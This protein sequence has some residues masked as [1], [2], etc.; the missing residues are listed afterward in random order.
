MLSLFILPSSVSTIAII[1]EP[2]FS[3][4]RSTSPFLSKPSKARFMVVSLVV[5]SL[6]VVISVLSR[7]NCELTVEVN[8]NAD[9]PTTVNATAAANAVCFTLII[10]YISNSLK[11]II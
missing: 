9:P 11:I 7:I 10:K 6:P 4:S 8:A 3:P 5:T 2:S 1:I